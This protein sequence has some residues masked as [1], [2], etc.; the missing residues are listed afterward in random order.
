MVIVDKERAD[1]KVR[2]DRARLSPSLPFSLARSLFLSLFLARSAY[3]FK[4]PAERLTVTHGEIALRR[5]CLA[6]HLSRPPA[7]P[8]ARRLV[9][10]R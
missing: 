6:D 7:R 4:T 1:T 2:R 5:P 9:P 10:G 8:S 3:R